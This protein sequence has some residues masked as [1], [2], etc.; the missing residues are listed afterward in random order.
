MFFLDFRY[1][2]ASYVGECAFTPKVRLRRRSSCMLVDLGVETVV[3]S[4]SPGVHP[5]AFTNQKVERKW[6]IFGF[7][8]DAPSEKMKMQM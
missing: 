6:A 7:Q 1:L 5:K 8:K 4:P 3:A 2:Y